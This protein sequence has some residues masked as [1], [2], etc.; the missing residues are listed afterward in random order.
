[1]A[2]APTPSAPSGVTRGTLWTSDK[3]AI[4]CSLT[5]DEKHVL[6]SGQAD[7]VLVPVHGLMTPPADT[8]YVAHQV[9][10]DAKLQASQQIPPGVTELQEGH[11]VVI[12]GL[13]YEVTNVDDGDSDQGVFVLQLRVAG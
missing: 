6:V 10:E 3:V 5:S 4:Q 8:G 1:M 2:P 11:E 9:R 12:N 7:S 13:T